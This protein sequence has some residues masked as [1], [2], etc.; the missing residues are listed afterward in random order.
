[1]NTPPGSTGPVGVVTR[2]ASLG[3]PER[4]EAGTASGGS[5]AACRSAWQ[6]PGDAVAP[7]P[8]TDRHDAQD[9]DGGHEHA[10]DARRRRR[11]CRELRR[12]PGGAR[13]HPVPVTSMTTPAVPAD[14]AGAGPR[15]RFSRPGAGAGGTVRSPRTHPW[16]IVGPCPTER[17]AGRWR[18]C[19]SATGLLRRLRGDGV[20]RPVIDPGL[21]GGLRD[22]LE[23]GLVESVAALPGG[24]DV[25]RVNKESLNQ[26]LLCEAHLV[27]G[28]QAPRV[29]T[30]ELA[31]GSM[32]DALFRQWVTTG[33]I[34]DPWADALAAFDVEGDRDGV[35]GLRRRPPRGAAGAGWRPRSPST[36]PTSSSGGP[37]PSPAW[38][39]RTQERL[40]VPL[41]GGRVVLA[42]VVDLVLG[43]PAQDRASVCLVELKSGAR[44]LEHRADLHFYALLEAL[45]SG[46]PP[47][48]IATY[49]SGTG[50]LDAEP[51]GEDTLVGALSRA[52]DGAIRLCRH[53]RRASSP[54]ATPTI[55]APGASGSRAALRANNGPAPM[56]RSAPPVTPSPARDRRD[57][58][59]GPGGVVDRRAAWRRSPRRWRRRRWRQLRD[60]ARARPA[61][62]WGPSSPTGERLQ[63]D[64][65]KV[66][67]AHR[68]PERCMSIDDTFVPSP[69]VV[70]ARR[71]CRRGQPVRAGTLPRAP[72]WPWPTCW[73]R[74][75]RTPPSLDH[76]CGQSPVVGPVVRGTARRWA[77]RG[78]RRGGHVGDATAHRRG[79]AAGVAPVIGGRDDWWQCPGGDADRSARAVPTCA[80]CVGPAARA[81]RGGD[82]AMPGRLARSSSA[83]P[84][85]VAALGR[86]APSRPV[87]GRRVSGPRAARSGSFPWT[88]AALRAT[89]AAV[90][91]GRGHVGR[92]PDREGAAA[93]EAAC[94]ARVSVSVDGAARLSGYPV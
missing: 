69:R 87:P 35:V 47:F 6:G 66:L 46:A 94:P 3:V 22:W 19:S 65:Y 84:A 74:G 79:L 37:C 48:R 9:E 25:V 58:G 43:S 14:P 60:D 31:R 76:R 40:E 8:P 68:H 1:M 51:V 16:G 24:A 82:G 53:R 75:S 20:P 64:A 67:L 11:S 30:V 54:P 12:V 49:Y 77:G 61:G 34:D 50:E 81:A 85:L 27:A 39:P 2:G 88:S 33:A 44:R 92:Q 17:R 10:E 28:R 5:V 15:G 78:V 7:H 42:G 4:G 57:D 72:P 56:W 45:R 21:A 91:A 63:I 55:C 29:G 83:T 80:R 38:L 52:L 26:V 93:P 62:L 59:P 70:P 73:P 89:A 32:V 36:P 71:R 13:G 23:D 18:G 90:V 41:C 86:D